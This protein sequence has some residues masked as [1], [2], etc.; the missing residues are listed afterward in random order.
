MANPDK[1]NFE[2]LL[3]DLELGVRDITLP[4]ESYTEGL[5]SLGRDMNRGGAD[6]KFYDGN[7]IKA[8]GSDQPLTEGSKGWAEDLNRITATG[9]VMHDRLREVIKYNKKFG[10]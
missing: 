7:N 9:T 10:L 2:D 1:K 5:D 4:V 3:N 8:F 6:A